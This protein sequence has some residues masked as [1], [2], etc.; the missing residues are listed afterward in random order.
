FPLPPPPDTL[1]ATLL[2]VN[3]DVLVSPVLSVT[4]IVM[5]LLPLSSGIEADQDVVPVA[6]PVAPVSEFDQVTEVT[7]FGAVA[8]AV[9]LTASGEDV[10]VV[11]GEVTVTV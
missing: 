1:A 2:T 3:V 11:G 10:V 7:V 9:P 5:T 6:V 8:L 4:V